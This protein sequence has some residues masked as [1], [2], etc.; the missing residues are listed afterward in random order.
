MKNMR[1][2]KKFGC[3]D[4]ETIRKKNLHKF[5]SNVISIVDKI[6]F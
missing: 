2:Y 5:V 4:E 3:L 6:F 1:C